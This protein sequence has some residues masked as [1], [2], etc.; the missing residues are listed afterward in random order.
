[1]IKDAHFGN[2]L[3]LRL[4]LGE[5]E[6]NTKFV[7]ADRMGMSSLP[8]RDIERVAVSLQETAARSAFTKSPFIGVVAI[9]TREIRFCSIAFEVYYKK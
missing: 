6:E 1:M 4:F 5:R 2:G 8:T 3:M 9:I 7:R